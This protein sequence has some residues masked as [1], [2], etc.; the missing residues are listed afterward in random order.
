MDYQLENLGPERFQQ[1]VQALLVAEFPGI[2]SYP[3][4]QPDGGR[5]ALRPLSSDGTSQKFAIFQVK[6]SRNPSAVP[7]ASKWI[8]GKGDEESEKIQR[9]VPRGASQYIVITNL[10]GTSHLDVGSID[11]VQR[12]LQTKFDIPV[13]CWWRDD[14]NRRLDGH[15]DIK[16]RYSEILSGHDFFRILVESTAGQDKERR[17]NAIRAFQ[18]TQYEEDVEV[19]F[20]QVELHTK[21]LDLFIDLPFRVTLRS[22]DFGTYAQ[23]E[24]WQ[25]QFNVHLSLDETSKNVSLSNFKEDG[26]VCGTATLLLCDYGY[27]HLTQVVVEGAPGQG[28]STLAQYLCQ[29]HRIRLLNKEG[30]LQGLNDIDKRSALRLPFKVD[31][32]DLAT[33]LSGVDPF[34]ASEQSVSESLSLE[35]FLA[36]L[37]RHFSGGLE[38]TA[39][40]LLQL[41]K[42]V[43]LLIVL[44]GLDEVVD[45]KQRTDVVAAVTK[46]IPRLKE[47]C[48]GLAVMI[49]S[50]PAAFAN[51]PGFDPDHFPNIDLLSVKRSQIDM[52]ADRWMDVRG[53][54]VKER[55]EFQQIL[56]EKLDAPHLRDL[57]RNPMQLTILLSLI[58]T[59]GSAL[60]DK[61]T[62][63]YDTY[64][65]LFFSR[66]SAKSSAVRKHIDLLKDL[67]RYL[68]WV[69]H[70][71]A[72]TNRRKSSG[73]ISAADLKEL[74][75]QY[76]KREKHPTDVIEEIFGA[77]LARVVM[78]VPR[79]QGT[80]EFEVQ[81]LRE[82]FAA[83]YLY[84]TA[85]YSPPGRE[86]KGTKP[87]R[88]DAI[89]RNFY[90]LNVVRFFSGCFS[91]GELLD[92]ADR[93]KELIA[94]PLLGQSR[95][96]VT[97]AAMLLSDWVF[98]QSPKAVKEI[99]TALITEDSL[100]RL[101]GSSVPR[102]TFSP[103][104][105]VPARSGG[106]TILA[107]A[108][109]YLEDPQLPLDQCRRL[110]PIVNAHGSEQEVDKRWNDSALA[111]TDTVKWLS[112]GGALGSLSRIE[113]SKLM[114]RISGV[115]SSRIVS[116][117]YNYER[118]D[119]LVTSESS[120]SL[121][122]YH[123]LS[124]SGPWGR[125]A[126][127]EW[128]FFLVPILFGMDRYAYYGIDSSFRRKEYLDGIK[129]FEVA[130]ART[131]F[132]PDAEP[133]FV[134]QCF[135]LSKNIAALQGNVRPEAIVSLIEEC[136]KMWGARPAIIA[137]SLRAAV[138]SKM[139]R[140]KVN[141]YSLSDAD[142]PMAYRFRA[143]RTRRSDASW[144]KS[145]LIRMEG[146]P[147]SARL[148]A[149]VA[150]FNFAPPS[151]IIELADTVG[152]G[153]DKMSSEEWSAVA[154]LIEH[155]FD[156]ISFSSK[157]E[158]AAAAVPD[159]K[160]SR[161]AYLLALN[162][163]RSIA[164]SLFLRHFLNSS[165]RETF[166]AEFR[167]MWA[168]EVA[169][170]GELEWPEALEIVKKTYAQGAAYQ[171]QRVLTQD[172]VLPEAVAR[173]ILSNSRAYPSFLWDAAER[174]A[175]TKARKAVRAVGQVARLDK[176]F[177]N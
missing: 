91:K 55:T 3:V 133:E 49:T 39:N 83:R 120:L 60:P 161:V 81:P 50:R 136:R 17:G 37:V 134:R 93:V 115:P 168:V 32:R 57:A 65:D 56:K 172:N 20:K 129:R 176:W 6:Y 77:M 4:A 69:L 28:K 116:I 158:R 153:L 72:E 22:N 11:T 71:T 7:N 104:I 102:P 100:R 111:R 103:V 151:I 21:L 29:V 79:I 2:T 173:E 165:E 159:I 167:Q 109:R 34:V 84:D 155:Q 119:C 9:L 156:R 112:I 53:L 86:Q 121:L 95:H 107:G 10:P 63:L 147:F 90:W 13:Q 30:D 43:P 160:S 152:P 62:S 24:P 117:L 87:D 12:E 154:R 54:S 126:L 80:Y 148:L 48:S 89:A 128:P 101:V 123:F 44:D 113:K 61:R 171:L 1:L 99:S 25:F 125:A 33:W 177:A 143:A 78:I 175:S 108:F 174:F 23:D 106:E 82:Y 16:L 118:Y 42:E 58:L 137:A 41:S 46:A 88:F 145:Q 122:S 170:A 27:R 105:Q 169:F 98:A 68:G 67:H 36:R 144:W 139:P 96:S 5:D 124:S 47:N 40:D 162:S 26:S 75:L 64:V 18:A 157:F 140:P 52:Y 74:L 92:L 131:D 51:S 94:D 164:R 76:L 142:V 73:R 150:L 127:G 130:S 8:L 70:S 66:E 149:N 132:L 59:Q 45:I 97:L 135:E 35:T 85:S 141:H 146:S 138:R 14:I 38:F 19:K 163:N 31:L 15:W 110:V 114:A 166:M